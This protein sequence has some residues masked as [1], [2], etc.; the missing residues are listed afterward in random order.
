MFPIKLGI[1]IALVFLVII[2]SMQ[3][4]LINRVSKFISTNDGIRPN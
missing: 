4:S 2:S 1:I 3:S